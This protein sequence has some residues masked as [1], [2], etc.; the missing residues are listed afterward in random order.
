VIRPGWIIVGLRLEMSIGLKRI[1]TSSV[2][3]VS[4]DRE[5]SAAPAA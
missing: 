3:S 2:Q 1:T 4:F 5:P